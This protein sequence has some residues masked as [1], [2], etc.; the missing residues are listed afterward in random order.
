[1]LLKVNLT[2]SAVLFIL[3]VFVLANV[4]VLLPMP[5]F[6]ATQA[7]YYVD[8]VG[9]NDS[10]NGTSAATAFATIAKARDVVRTVNSNM[11][12]DIY[13]YLMNGMYT[14]GSTLEFGTADSGTNGYNV[15]Y[16][17]YTDAAPVISGGVD[18]TTGWTLY[19]AA[20]NIYKRT[21]VNWN[22]RQLYV[23]EQ[24]GI[25]ARK[26]NLTDEVTGGPYLT[27]TNN[28]Y[29]YTVNSADI[30][31]WANSGTA[32]MVVVN[33]W[34]QNRGRIASYSGNTVYFKSPESGFAYNHHNQSTVPYY[35]E[36]AYELLDAEGE[37]F[38]DTQNTTLYY[39]PRTG[40]TMNTT[41][42]TAPKLETLVK[43]EGTDNSNKV[44]NIQFYG[45]TF[46]YSN[47]LAPSSYG[48]VD[49]Q[50][51]FRYQ[52]A[53]G[54]NNSEIRNTARYNAPAS[55]L[56]LKYASNIKLDHNTFKYAGSWGVMGY[57][58]T[59]NN[60]IVWNTFYKNAGGGIAMGIVGDQWDAYYDPS[61]V[62]PDGQS[63]YDTI[64]DNTIDSIGL[65]Y[66]DAVG[67]GAMLPQ[68]MTIAR[69]EVK[70][71]S[72]T[73]I[74]IGWNWDDSDHSMTGNQVFSNNIHHV[75]KL[76]D[77]GGGIYSLGR[78]NGDT[79]FHHNYIH[80]I[81]R[82]SSYSG[83]YPIAAIY[84]DNGS[85]YKTA[86]NN[87]INN[88]ENAFYAAN[89]PNH[90]NIFQ[91]N[92][93]N[94]AWGNYGGNVFRNNTSVSGQSWPQ[95]ALDI[96]N[97]AGP[98]GTLPPTP[99]PSGVNVALNKTATASSEYSSTYSEKGSTVR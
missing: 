95:A 16:K 34:S 98:G 80:D 64:T 52:T 93:S 48:Y 62:L 45:S 24:R 18:I 96:M 27:A 66:A 35:F 92:F 78:M 57:E 38:L 69:N 36:N 2:K 41:Q 20:K 60:S 7:T 63:Q 33:H 11:T 67:I 90:D 91:Y 99:T 30:G 43:I 37:W 81:A 19:D 32:E 55:M 54:G 31:S 25:K 89:P 23:N 40:E 72:Y 9:G 82:S 22:F 13:V 94:V 61:Y 75:I 15:I 86:E 3:I 71:L 53:G 42:I 79:N 87:V 58:G 5:T 14:L 26:P 97:A 21:G 17:A 68:N 10:N 59:D 29:P 65:D 4:M 84:F 77:D 83:G 8:P 88:A 1:M 74:T 39:K 44:R 49:V 73:G 70:N 6:A 51:G 12:G 56:Q 46:K 47:W 28:A 76:L 85:S 50:A